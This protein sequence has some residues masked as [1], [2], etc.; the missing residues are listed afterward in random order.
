ML[1]SQ[2]INTRN[3]DIEATIEATAPKHIFDLEI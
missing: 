1:I 3:N 2:L